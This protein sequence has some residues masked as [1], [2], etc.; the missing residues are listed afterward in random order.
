MEKRVRARLTTG[1]GRRF[2]LT[3]GVAFLALAALLVWREHAYAAWATG[4]LGALL[5]AAGLVLPTR[6]GPVQAAWMGFAAVLSKVTTP[7]FMSVVYFVVLTP[8]GF[9]MR[10]FGRRPLRH[11]PVDGGFWVTRASGRG[12]D[13]RRQF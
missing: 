2:G 10:L 4:T 7:I 6:L 1:E 9:L 13:L 8:T 3:V 12:H 11:Q 5:V